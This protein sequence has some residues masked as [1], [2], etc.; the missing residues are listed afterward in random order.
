MARPGRGFG[1][2]ELA[3]LLDLNKA[4]VFRLLGALEAEGMVVRDVS[5]GYRLGP[6]LITLGASA[7][8]STDLSVA[9][10]DELVALVDLTGETATLEVLVGTEA[11][12]IGEVQGRFLLGSAPE[13]GRRSPA[14]VTSTGK[15]L[16]EATSS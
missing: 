10:H 14:H 7:L 2:T 13:L 9:A 3:V 4:A 11:L 8:G 1:I 16:L 6:E 5:G 12:I 15:V